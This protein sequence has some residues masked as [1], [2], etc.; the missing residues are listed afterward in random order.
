MDSTG[1]LTEAAI[2]A[3]AE[4]AYNAYGEAAGWRAVGGHPMP[5]W[6]DQSPR[7]QNLW[8]E[9]ARG[10]LGLPPGCAPGA[11]APPATP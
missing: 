3:A 2:E 5:R 10:A 4:R 7:L 11:L 1:L 9:A 6:E 8:A